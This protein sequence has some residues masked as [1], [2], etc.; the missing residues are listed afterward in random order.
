MI[1]GPPT[2]VF[3]LA[4]TTFFIIRPL[5]DLESEPESMWTSPAMLFRSLFGPLGAVF[6]AFFL[7]PTGQTRHPPLSPPKLV[8]PS[9]FTTSLDFSFSSEVLFLGVMEDLASAFWTRV[10]FRAR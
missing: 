7:L 9:F 4:H 3:F 8:P 1:K 5:D 2:V 10:G 6:D